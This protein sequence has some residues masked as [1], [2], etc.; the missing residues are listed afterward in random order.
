MNSASASSGCRSSGG[1]EGE[2]KAASSEATREAREDASSSA[3][4]AR[5]ETYNGKHDEG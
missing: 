4:Q 2:V 3:Q 5:K 1:A